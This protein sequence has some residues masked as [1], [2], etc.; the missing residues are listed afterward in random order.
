MLPSFL[1][2][3]HEDLSLPKP[4]TC[5]FVFQFSGDFIMSPSPVVNI[6]QLAHFWKPLWPC[7]QA[8]FPVPGIYAGGPQS[9]CCP[10]F[11][12]QLRSWLPR[13]PHS[14]AN[15]FCYLR[16]CFQSILRSHK[17]LLKQSSLLVRPGESSHSVT[18]VQPLKA[19]AEAESESWF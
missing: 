5:V 14:L 16:W 1:S 17:V 11:W 9:C 15:T 18:I 6:A 4:G 2:A 7:P 12:F 19:E 13:H 8:S 10:W 3:V